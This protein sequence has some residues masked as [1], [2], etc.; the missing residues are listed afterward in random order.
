MAGD[1]YEAMLTDMPRA[2]RSWRCSSAGLRPAPTWPA[3][4]P[5]KH[6][7]I[8]TGRAFSGSNQDSRIPACG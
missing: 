5:D 4:P 2:V 3:R 6:R 8:R 1:G 7:Y